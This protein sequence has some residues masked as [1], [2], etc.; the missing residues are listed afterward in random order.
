[1]SFA[2]VRGPG[3]PDQACD[4]IAAAI[5]EEYVRRD[6]ASCLRLHVSGGRGAIFVSGEVSSSADF[7]VS[8]IVRRAL[9]SCGVNALMEP[10]IA[11]EVMSPR[12][13]IARASHETVHAFGYVTTQTND[14]FP[15]PV[16][17]AR[18]FAREFE[19]RRTSDA[20]WFW[21]GSDYEVMVQE[22]NDAPLVIVR[23]EHVATQEVAQVR[24]AISS[25]LTTRAPGIEV[26]V[27]PSGEE[28]SAGLA[29]RMGGSGRASSIDQYGTMLPMSPSGVGQQATH[30]ANMGAWLCR[31][32][33]LE[34]VRRGKGK[35]IAV[36]A[37][38]LPLESRPHHVRIRNEKGE[39]LASQIDL[40]KFDLSK[41]PESFL[42][43]HLV[44]A[45]L[46]HPFDGSVTLPW[47]E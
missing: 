4:L 37:M 40:E 21:L 6:P 46:R 33:A 8:A 26:R 1:M 35:A 19:R 5:V 13:A 29:G 44:T 14:G 31:Q 9:G 30:P 17:L 47:E 10:F 16:S 45:S 20:D 3:Q 42:T 12:T 22:K 27:N 38:W 43:P 25:L 34:L 11:L 41:V 24:E 39:D 28:T 23:A 18:D 2:R 15:R 7:D 32:V 36:H